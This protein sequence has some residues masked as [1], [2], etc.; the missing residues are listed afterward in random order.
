MS[1]VVNCLV[2][3][4]TTS[5]I[6]L[7]RSALLLIITLTITATAVESVG[8]TNAV[9][10]NAASHQSAVS[11]Q[12]AASVQVKP[13][14]LLVLGDSISAAYGIQREAGWVAKLTERL[15][16]IDT[17]Y[18]V[19]NAS[20]SGETTQGGLARLP[21]ALSN[22]NPD[23]VIIELGGNDGMRG[24]PVSDIEHNLLAMTRASTAAGADV[25]LLGMHI[26]PNYGPR[27][28]RGFHAAFTNTAAQAEAYLV[29]FFLEGIALQAGMMQDDG[30]HPTVAA[31]SKLLNTA[32]QAIQMCLGQRY[33]LLL[34]VP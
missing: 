9:A 11:D 32:W 19:I 21:Q 18:A 2:Y 4:R 24:Y 27:Y 28:S 34:K 16:K 8:T 5:R 14:T 10:K 31:Q 25:I 6:L 29:P 30:I 22:H 20:V 26:P 12:S 15:Q 23:L 33:P 13:L 1:V 3:V 7:R 17:R